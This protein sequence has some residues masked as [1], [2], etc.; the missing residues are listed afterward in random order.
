M[1]AIINFMKKIEEDTNS[2]VV[3][4]G[5]IIEVE[6]EAIIEAGEDTTA[7]E[8]AADAVELRTTEAVLHTRKEIMTTEDHMVRQLIF[9]K[10]F[11]KI[12]VFLNQQEACTGYWWTSKFSFLRFLTFLPADN[13]RSSND[14]G[15]PFFKLS[16]LEDPWKHLA[17]KQN[18]LSKS[19][20]IEALAPVARPDSGDYFEADYSDDETPEKQTDAMNLSD[21]DENALVMQTN[22]SFEE[23]R[24]AASSGSTGAVSTTLSSELSQV[25]LLSSSSSEQA[26]QPAPKKPSLLS[27]LPPPKF[28]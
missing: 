9:N 7:E 18:Q 10:P 14:T 2:I 24:A 8:M 11:P 21:D 27:M 23:T 3:E 17:P 16:F 28:T 6:E 22:A 15:N 20:D 5:I 12:L 13:Q 19:A 1:A 26:D 4:V 25:G